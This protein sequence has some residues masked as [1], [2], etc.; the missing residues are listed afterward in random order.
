[1]QPEARNN[2]LGACLATNENTLSTSYAALAMRYGT[3]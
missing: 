2:A 3:L 1:M